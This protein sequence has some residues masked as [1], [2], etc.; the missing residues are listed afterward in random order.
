MDQIVQFF[1]K[2]VTEFTWRRLLFVISLVFLAI[3]GVTFFERYTGHFRFSRIER[4][5]GLLAQLNEQTDAVAASPKEATKQIHSALLDDLADY[6]SPSKS[7][8]SAPLWVKKAGAAAC[9]WFILAVIFYFVTKRGEYMGL[10]G[11]L[12]VVAVP[13]TFIGAILPDYTQSW[14]NFYGYPI[15]VSYTHLTL[16]TILLV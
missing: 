16:P 6:V 2:L 12:L 4:A 3:V 15:A 11:G 8:I 7:D 10:I 14:I 9:P 13:L 5:T 1:E